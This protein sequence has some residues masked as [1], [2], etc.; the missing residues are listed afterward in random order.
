M[1]GVDLYWMTWKHAS[2]GSSLRWRPSGLGFWAAFVCGAEQ[3]D[4]AVEPSLSRPRG[5]AGG[6]ISGDGAV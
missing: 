1:I 3:E 6:E 4:L 5:C 2:G